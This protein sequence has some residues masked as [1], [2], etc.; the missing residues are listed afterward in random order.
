MLFLADTFWMTPYL[1]IFFFRPTFLNMY[2]LNLKVQLTFTCYL[3][4]PE[5]GYGDVFPNMVCK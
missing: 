3:K 4:C 5:A 1:S 2:F